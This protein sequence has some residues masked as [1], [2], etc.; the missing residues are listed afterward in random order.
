MNSIWRIATNTLRQT[1]RER[2]FFNILIFGLAMIL[3]SLVV[4]NL[5]YGSI[6]RVVRSIGLTGVT[7]A[8]D[9]IALLVAVSLVHQEI[10][11]KTLF[12]VLVRPIARWQY[13]VGRYLGLMLAVGSALAGFSAIYLLAVVIG[14][15]TPSSKDALALLMILP[16]ASVLG[17]FGIML[18]SFSTPTLSA[19][20]GLGFW[21]AATAVDDFVRLTADAPD[22][23]KV[24]ARG[25]YYALPA[26]ERFDFR[27]AALYDLPVDAT[28]VFSSAAYGICYAL[29]LVSLAALI[30][31]RREMV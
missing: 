27:Q 11:R 4:G 10:D 13:I 1:V 5:T 28:L 2:L 17:A 15:G 12:V 22:S 26:F 23:L 29:A 21:I 14:M 30:L 24:L 6:F 25:I 20:V 18:S 31:S 19:G 8:V 16:E 9:L 3:L 7:L